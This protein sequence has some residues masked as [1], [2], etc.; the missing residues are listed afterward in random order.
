MM[1]HTIVLLIWFIAA[2][3]HGAEQENPLTKKELHEIQTTIAATKEFFDNEFI[4][5][6]KRAEAIEE[7]EKYEGRPVRL[8]TEVIRVTKEHIRVLAVLDTVQNDNRGRQYPIVIIAENE[9]VA[10][11]D[12]NRRRQGPPE[13]ILGLTRTSVSAEMQLKTGDLVPLELAKTLRNGDH[14]EISGKL[15]DIFV[16]SVLVGFVIVDAKVQK[17]EGDEK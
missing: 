5:E 15:G 13:G 6:A 12:S 7:I 8:T 9:D 14:L 11:P 3:L 16:E 2:P 4:F 17:M 10:V 1:R